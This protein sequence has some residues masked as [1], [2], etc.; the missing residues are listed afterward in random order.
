MLLSLEN[1][2][3][4]L[5]GCCGTWASSGALLCDSGFSYLSFPWDICLDRGLK[6]VPGSESPLLIHGAHF[7]LDV[8][9]L[10]FDI[11]GSFRRALA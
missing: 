9:S 1:I 2:I 6:I 5:R 3:V 11:Q 10:G 8:S 7:F 4:S